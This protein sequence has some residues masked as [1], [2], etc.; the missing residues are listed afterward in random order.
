LTDNRAPLESRYAPGQSDRAPYPEVRMAAVAAR[1][2]E[3]QVLILQ[4]LA[5]AGAAGLTRDQIT[6]KAGVAPT[7]GNVGPVFAHLKDTF[8]ESLTARG[9]VQVAKRPDEQTTWEITAKGLSVA[10]KYRARKKV[11]AAKVPPK[12]LDPVVKKFLPTRAYGLEL[13]TDDDLK[14][15]RS[16][17]GADHA[18]LPLTALRQ[19]IVNRRKQGAFADKSEGRRRAIERVLKDFGLGGRVHDGFLSEEQVA[20]LEAML[21]G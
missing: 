15:V 14:E 19:Q 3:S 2:S 12:T 9:L 10:D 21:D 7:A 6:A 1:L 17:L 18:D 4:A 20:A 5:K 13:W 16:Q 11:D 8:P